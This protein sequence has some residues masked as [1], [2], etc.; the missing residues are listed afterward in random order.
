MPE[1]RQDLISG[2]WV[3]I[4]TDRAKRP[5]TFACKG[6]DELDHASP[7]AHNVCS[8]NEAMTPPE[9]F[10]LTG[11]AEATRASASAG[12]RVR[13]VRISF[14]GPRSGSKAQADHRRRL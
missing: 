2:R 10:A 11:A 1:F 8:G 14:P 6:A 3:I 7:P 5:E 9:V 13:V 4:A 12:W